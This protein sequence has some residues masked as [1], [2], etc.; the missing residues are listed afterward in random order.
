MQ[1]AWYNYP[2]SKLF[3]HAIEAVRRL[4]T[5]RQNE[6]AEI[7]ETAATQ[8]SQRLSEVQ[9]KAVDEGLADAAA[10]RFAT[11]DDVRALFR[12]YRTA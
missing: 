3:E 2:M 4:P 9:L 12:K 1:R 6:I 7:L 10:N 8:M 11:T 5:E